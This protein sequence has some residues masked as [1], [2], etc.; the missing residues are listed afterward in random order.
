MFDLVILGVGPDGHIL[1]VFPGSPAIGSA[2]LAL[3][4][5]APTHVEPHVPR[6]TFNPRILDTAREVLVITAGGAK[7]ELLAE[8]LGGERDPDRLPVQ[9]A[10]RA[11]A[12]WLLDAAAASRLPGRSA[13]T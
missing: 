13:G 4:I 10:R 6:V 3:G 12:T 9:L 1:S 7:A 2:D 11:G 8:A 5:P